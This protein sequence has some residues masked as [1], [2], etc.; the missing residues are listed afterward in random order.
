MLHVFKF[1]QSRSLLLWIIDTESPWTQFKR[2]PTNSSPHPVPGVTGG[3]FLMRKLPVTRANVNKVEM[4]VYALR[5][6]GGETPAP[7]LLP[8]AQPDWEAAGNLSDDEGY[9]W[10]LSYSR[11]GAGK[12]SYGFSKV[13][14]H[15]QLQLTI[16]KLHSQQ[17]A[18]FHSRH[19]K[20]VM[21]TQCHVNK[22][23]RILFLSLIIDWLK[24]ASSLA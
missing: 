8:A 17:R 7:L 9:Y 5:V 4:A 15:F 20:T 6:R 22:E 13:S 21:S 11:H 14:W 18:L 12:H 3:R 23:T 10:T 19:F 1:F 24:P 2:H 16:R